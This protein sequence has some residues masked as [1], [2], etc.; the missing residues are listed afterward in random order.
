MQEIQIHGFGCFPNINNFNCHRGV[1]IYTKRYLDARS[2]LTKEKDFQEHACCKTEMSGKTSLYILCLYRSPN[3]SSEN[4]KLL[5]QL[6]LI[7]S[8]IGGK[9]LIWDFYFQTI[10]VDNL[11]TP[12]LFNH[13]ASEFLTAAQDAFLFQYVQ[14]PT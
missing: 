8:L 13:N 14:S 6:I 12:H 11:S 9:L 4:N 3:N 1:G 5:N 7:T 2:Y 10:N